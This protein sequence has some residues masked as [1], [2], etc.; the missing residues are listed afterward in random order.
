M[1]QT[2]SRWETGEPSNRPVDLRLL[3]DI[4][5][6]PAD[7]REA[8]VTLAQQA[9][10]RDWWHQYASAVPDWFQVYVGLE[11]EASTVRI[12]AAELVPGLLQTEGYYRAFLASVAPGDPEIGKKVKVRLAPLGAPDQWR[13]A[14]LLGGAERGGDPPTGRR[15]RGHEQAAWLHR[16]GSGIAK[17]DSP[18][19]AVPGRRTFG[20]GGPYSLLG[21]FERRVHG[22]D[23]VRDFVYVTASAQRPGPTQASRRP[24]RGLH[25]NSR[26]VSRGN[27]L[28]R[29]SAYRP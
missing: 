16:C 21:E 8:L 12:Y 4:Y 22:G 5:D 26:A 2:L 20:D 13:P 17:R 29:P 19:S 9:K 11:T 6:I 25:P 18:G 24:R 28:R 3:L 15:Q 14:E 10:E 23:V 27:W 1:L 7:E